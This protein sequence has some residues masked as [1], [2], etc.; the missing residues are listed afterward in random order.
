[1]DEC[2]AN[3][4]VARSHSPRASQKQRNHETEESEERQKKMV[5]KK[6][7]SGFII[8]RGFSLIR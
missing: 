2:F 3:L 8:L 1:M 7:K 5:K 6:K 4:I